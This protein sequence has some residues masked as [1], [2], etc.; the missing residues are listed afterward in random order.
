MPTTGVVM[1]ESA[2]THAKQYT[3]KIRDMPP[4]DKPREKLLNYGPTILSIHELLAV[5]L[6]TGTKKEDVLSMASR[7]LKE[8][9]EHTLSHHTNAA[10][11]AKD[12]NIPVFKA[13][14]I[15]ACSELGRRFFQ[16]RDS[17]PITLR[18]AKDVFEYVY[19]MRALSKEQLRGIYLNTHY[20]IIHDEIISMGTIDTNLVHPREVFKPAIE[21][22]AAAIILVH[23]HPS[24]IINPSQADREITEQLVTVGQLVG[25]PLI[26]HVIVNRDAFFSIEAHYQ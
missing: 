22:G 12:L 6:H 4:E 17:G 20:R 18:T 26:D 5:V 8:Y 11:L 14:Q 15:V 24:G 13:L 25:I 1:N 10:Q 19:D 3:L 16:T 2:D 9:G 7:V 23:N 21:Y